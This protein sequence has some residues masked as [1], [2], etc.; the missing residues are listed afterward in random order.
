MAARLTA[1]KAPTEAVLV[2]LPHRAKVGVK[3]VHERLSRGDV[4][5]SDGILVYAVQPA[6][7]CGSVVRP[8]RKVFREEAEQ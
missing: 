6:L 2:R 4:H 5:V 1:H 8:S 7:C 3:L